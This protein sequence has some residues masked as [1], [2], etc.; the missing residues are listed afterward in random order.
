MKLFVSRMTGDHCGLAQTFVCGI[1]RNKG[2][3]HWR[4]DRHNYR[5]KSPLIQFIECVTI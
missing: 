4:V 3:T 5:V 1:F 2:E